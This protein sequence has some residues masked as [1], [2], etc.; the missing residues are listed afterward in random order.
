MTDLILG[1]IFAG[2]CV[3]F[4]LVYVIYLVLNRD[5]TDEFDYFIGIVI[6]P[7][8]LAA[9]TTIYAGALWF[10]FFYEVTP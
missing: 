4:L 10:I 3:L 6:V 2:S 8:I 1:K 7:P 9:I 5:H